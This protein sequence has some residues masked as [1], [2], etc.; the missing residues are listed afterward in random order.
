MPREHFLLYSNQLFWAFVSCTHAVLIC[1]YQSHLFLVSTIQS[2]IIPLRTNDLLVLNEILYPVLTF[3]SIPGSSSE[4]YAL[5]KE[6]YSAQES[7]SVRNGSNRPLSIFQTWSL[8]IRIPVSLHS[9][10]G[11][12]FDDLLWTNW[13]PWAMLGHQCPA[14][15]VSRMNMPSF[16]LIDCFILLFCS[17]I[18]Y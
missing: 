3:R 6:F 10:V 18:T 15:V 2:N 1:L 11:Y 17:C 5:G 14:K 9:L 7:S 4:H 8:S 16:H 13:L 12:W